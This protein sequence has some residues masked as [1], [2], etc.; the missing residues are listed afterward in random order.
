MDQ[1]VPLTR[2]MLSGA[3]RCVRGHLDAASAFFD[4]SLKDM[5]AKSSDLKRVAMRA[6]SGDLLALDG[7]EAWSAGSAGCGLRDRRRGQ[8]RRR[9]AAGLG[10]A[11]G[12][13][14]LSPRAADAAP[15]SHRFRLSSACLSVF[16]LGSGAGAPRCPS[17]TGAQRRIPRIVTAHGSVSGRHSPGGAGAWWLGL[18]RCPPTMLL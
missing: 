1:S 10:V 9:P 4:S 15:S 13:E 11:G 7:F 5:E 17:P 8:G 2:E 18:C 16:G 3:L 6:V 12:C 14:R